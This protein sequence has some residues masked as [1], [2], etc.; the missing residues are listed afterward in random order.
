MRIEVTDD[1]LTKELIRDEGF[2]REP[3]VDTVNVV[4]VG[5]GHNLK[6]KPLPDGWKYPL[7]HDQIEQLLHDDLKY[8]FEELDNRLNWWRSMSYARQRVIVNM[9]FNLG[10]AGLLTFKNTLIY[11]QSGRYKDA[12]NNM[13]MSKWAKQVGKR[14]NR[15]AEMMMDG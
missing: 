2:R 7:T 3:Y 8:V 12:A 11:M 15:L 1:L 9:A 4:T 5:V 14:A 10:I 6:A 13:L